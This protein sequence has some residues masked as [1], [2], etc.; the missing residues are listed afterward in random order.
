MTGPLFKK[1]EDLIIRLKEK[2]QELFE[3]LEKAS[4]DGQDVVYVSL[5]S[6]VKWC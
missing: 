6:M 2:D 4:E 5:G 3:W 1:H